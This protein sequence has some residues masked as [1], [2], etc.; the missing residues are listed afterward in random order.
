V[1][2]LYDYHRNTISYGRFQSL[3]AFRGSSLGWSA[4]Q[5]TFGPPELDV[6]RGNRRWEASLSNTT[7]VG[8]PNLEL[9]SCLR[10]LSRIGGGLTYESS[11]SARR[12]PLCPE[13]FDMISNSAQRR[14]RYNIYDSLI[15][16]E[17]SIEIVCIF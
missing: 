17:P 7:A 10:D 8:E 6:S 16:R 13:Q 4:S 11:M 9:L 1:S 5:C 3:Q 15:T 14:T 12:A 2:H